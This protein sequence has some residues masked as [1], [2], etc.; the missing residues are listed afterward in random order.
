M[1]IK[2]IFD[3]IFSGVG[4]I[5]LLPFFIII[6]LLIKLDCKGPVFFRQERIGKNFRIFKIYKFRSMTANAENNRLMIT[7]SDDERVTFI[8]KF[9]RRYKL[10]ELPQLMNVFK[11]EMS[12]VGPRPEV[13]KYTELF[14]SDYQILLKIRPGMTDPA[15]IRF[16]GEEHLLAF[17]KNAEEKYI[18]DILPNKI[19]LSLLY[20]RNHNFITDLQLIF[21]TFLK[22]AQFIGKHGS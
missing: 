14:K 5:F 2:R 1:M 4:I 15:S 16:S 9:L 18:E 11:G 7:A 8:G 6:A 17:S 12:L 3:I 20:V 21:K 19:Q 10:D 13:K 22:V